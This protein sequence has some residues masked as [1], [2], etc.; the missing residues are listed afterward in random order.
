MAPL[1][2][3]NRIA[4]LTLFEKG[5]V[6][7]KKSSLSDREIE[8]RVFKAYLLINQEIVLRDERVMNSADHIDM[9]LKISASTFSLLFPVHDIVNVNEFEVLVCQFIK[10]FYLFEF[11]EREEKFEPILKAFYSHHQIAGWKEYLMK[12]VG[13][14][15]IMLEEE[16]ERAITFKVH[17]GASYEQ[18]CRFLESICFG[19][20]SMFEDDFKYL[21]SNPIKKNQN[22]TFTVIF[23][24]FFFELIYR[25]IYFRLND[26]N[27]ALTGNDRVKG[28]RSIYCDNF[29]EKTLMTELLNQMFRNRYITFSGSELK[30]KLK[31]REPDY[32][33]RNGR[34]IFLF[35]SKDFNFRAELKNSGDWRHYEDQLKMRLYYYVKGGKRKN[36]AILQLFENIDRLLLEKFIADPKCPPKGLK[37]YSIIVV[38]HRIFSISGLNSFIKH[39]FNEESRRRKIDSSLDYSR[40]R[41]PVIIDI[42]TLIL[43]KDLIEVKKIALDTIIDR[44]LSFINRDLSK[45]YRDFEDHKSAFDKADYSFK[46]FFLDE[47]K[48][49]EWRWKPKLFLEKAHMTFS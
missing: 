27:D 40:V 4:S 44:Y 20:S 7:D 14:S 23:R 32:Y 33:V 42:D 29:S 11:L 10:S 21:R 24:L 45:R 48:R 36:G 19:K 25:S 30:T 12:M 46:Q 9:P 15:K 38:H 43:M 8:E 1:I 31:N 28:F 17:P 39:W 47:L 37:I 41:V 6:S 35:E 13:F 22:G 34:K 26:L 18:D 2:I 16:L 49:N 3:I 5:A